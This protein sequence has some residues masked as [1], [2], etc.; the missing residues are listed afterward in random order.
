MKQVTPET[1]VGP[2]RHEQRLRRLLRRGPRRWLVVPWRLVIRDRRPGVT[3]LMYHRIG[4]NTALE[5]DLPTRVFARQLAYLKRH[6]RVVSLEDALALARPGAPPLR[7]DLLVL[8]FDDGC[9]EMHAVVLPL[10]RRWNIPA[11][12]Y[13]PTA[14]VEEQRPLDWGHLALLP[15]RQRPR[16]LTWAQAD[17]M[18]R[19]GLV[20]IGAHTHTHLNCAAAA[21]EEIRHEIE[22]SN[23]LLAQRLG[24]TPSHFCYPYGPTSAAARA[25]VAG[26][27]DTAVVQGFARLDATVFDP[28]DLPRIPV[29]QSDGYWL[30]RLKL[31]FVDFPAAP[32]ARG[33]TPGC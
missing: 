31:S 13:L 29:S 11:T 28:L 15:E 21:A 27:Y 3:I 26:Y 18:L 14:Y 6:Y 9:V 12:M 17:E 8:T 32:H 16:P 24:I 23:G 2:P 7:E 20:T 1:A 4:G 10:L 22:V 19:S 30:F 5:V 33:M 25:V